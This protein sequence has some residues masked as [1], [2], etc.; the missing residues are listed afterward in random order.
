M[1]DNY[2]QKGVWVSG[3]LSV[4]VYLRAMSGLT[5]LYIGAVISVGLAVLAISASG[6]HSDNSLRFFTYL[7]LAAI[8]GLLKI[9]LPGVTG[10]LSAGFVI[11]LLAVSELST[12]E[13]VAVA[14]VSVMVQYGWHS[15]TRLRLVQVCFSISN[16]AI[17]AWLASLLLH[18]RVLEEI[19]LLH[20][21]RLAIASVIYFFG[22]SLIV[23][24][25]IAL[26]ESKPFLNVLKDYYIWS[27]PFYLVAAALV[28]GIGILGGL[29]GWQTAVL[30]IPAV[31]AVYQVWSIYA[32]RVE[33][34]RKRQQEARIHAEEMSALH[35]RTIHT[36]AMAIEARDRTTHDHLRRVQIYAVEI[37]Q[38]MGLDHAELEALRTAAVLHDIGKLGVPEHIISK[39]GRLTPEE[40]EKVQAHPV[41][42]AEILERVNFP[43]EVV[44]IVRSH[45]ERWDGSGYPAGL[46]GTDIPVGARI[47]SVVDCFDALASDRQYRKALSTEQAIQVVRRAAGKDFDPDV[48]ALLADRFAELEAKVRAASSEE[49]PMLSRQEIREAV[50]AAGFQSAISAGSRSYDVSALVRSACLASD[51]ISPAD[52]AGDLAMVDFHLRSQL[53][54]ELMAVFVREGREIRVRYLTGAGRTDVFAPGQVGQ[55]LSGWVVE[56]GRPILNGN[57]RLDSPVQSRSGQY[58]LL[59]ASSVPILAGDRTVGALTVYSTQPDAFAVRDLQVLWGMSAEIGAR[60]LESAAAAAIGSREA[61]VKA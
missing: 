13:T 51:S 2:P 47:L 57:G 33:G 48:V 23:A 28:E 45:H 4:N 31:F 38:A 22:N 58:D 15:T 19:G 27:L 34:E 43:Y 26:T 53:G 50:P 36:L 7:L 21:L 17:A 46:R 41:V 39:P 40:F 42:G 20:P 54:Y 3:L 6:W 18:S 59:S 30:V 12:P 5:Q 44:P 25:V 11:V 32:D 29:V 1:Q 16:V 35:V 8:S 24:V 61:Y 60:L 10:T 37:G 14:V 55:G 9:K 56:E 52:F 49:P